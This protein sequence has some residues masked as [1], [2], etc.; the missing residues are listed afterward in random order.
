LKIK[1]KTS[2]KNCRKEEEIKSL[3]FRICSQIEYDLG[4]IEENN[5]RDDVML[6]EVYEQW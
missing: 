3:D 1:G 4:L 2:K 6:V 5:N